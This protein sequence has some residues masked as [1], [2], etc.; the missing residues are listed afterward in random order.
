MKATIKALA[1]TH[2][3]AKAEYRRILFDE[4]T[5]PNKGR[6]QLGQD[7]KKPNARPRPPPSKT[8][9]R[10]IIS[11]LICPLVRIGRKHRPLCNLLDRWSDAFNSPLLPVEPRIPL[12]HEI[13]VAGIAASSFI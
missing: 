1:E 6:G 9:S 2:S 7:L 12:K 8:G 3:R 10:R 13:N 4:L 5:K 11:Y